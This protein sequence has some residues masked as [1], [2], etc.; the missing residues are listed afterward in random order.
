[1]A[2]TNKCE[3]D[4]DGA[5]RKGRASYSCPLCGADVSLAWFLYQEA[6]YQEEEFL[7]KPLKQFR[8]R[9]FKEQD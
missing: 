3:H 1:M 5:I 6:L 7:T 4:L 2:L 8:T 9:K